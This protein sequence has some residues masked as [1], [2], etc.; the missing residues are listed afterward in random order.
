[1]NWQGL[2][3]KTVEEY[4]A[5]KPLKGLSSRAHNHP[6]IS[7]LNACDWVISGVG[8]VCIVAQLQH[9]ETLVGNKDLVVGNILDMIEA[10]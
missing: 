6:S 8:A 2:T 9:W 4:V 10:T 1:V 5:Q 7:R 3:S